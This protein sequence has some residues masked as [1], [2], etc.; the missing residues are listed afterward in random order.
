MIS[1]LL[2]SVCGGHGVPTD[3]SKGEAVGWFTK[4]PNPNLWR[5]NTSGCDLRFRRFASQKLWG[6][7]R[8]QA[9][10]ITGSDLHTGEGHPVSQT[11]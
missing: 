5:T 8:C 1:Q 11:P 9:F 10:W 6:C 7:G 2:S 3:T 4:N